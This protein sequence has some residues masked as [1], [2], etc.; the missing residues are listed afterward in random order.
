MLWGSVHRL[1][2]QRELQLLIRSEKSRRVGQLVG[3]SRRGRLAEIRRQSDAYLPFNYGCGPERRF[4]HSGV[5]HAAVAAF[6][7]GLVERL[8]GAGNQLA[9]RVR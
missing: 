1:C 4:S 2:W 3:Q 7:F 8:V 5:E 6:V 9:D